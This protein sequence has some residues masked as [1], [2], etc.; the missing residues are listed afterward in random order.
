[1]AVDRME[2]PLAGRLVVVTGSSSGIGRAI[3][4][5]CARAGA[6]VGLSFRGG[7]EAAMEVLGEVERHGRRG[8]CG[9]LEVGEAASVDEYFSG[10]EE[11][12]G[13]V[14]VLVNNAGIDGRRVEVVEM[15]LGDWDEVMAVNLR[16]VFL[17]VRRVLPGM[18]ARGRGVVLNISSVHE[19]IPWAGHAAYCAAKAGVAMLT[20][21]LALEMQ[22]NGV[23]VVG[24]APGAVRTPINRSVWSTPEGL[25]DLRSKIPLGR[26]AE[27][28]EIARVARFLVSDAASYLTGAT[29]TVDGGMT[30]YPSFAHGG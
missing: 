23:R 10:V 12:G 8:Y 26:M 6:D 3:A 27:V 5:E 1:M 16:G 9:R 22:G 14:D 11:W 21:T 29:V 17:C 15:E 20:R 24:L 7:R 4:L 2:L 18:V 25:A 19:R 30:A 13:A 28:E